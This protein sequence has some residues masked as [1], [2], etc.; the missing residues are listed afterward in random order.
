MPVQAFDWQFLTGYLQ[1]L[2]LGT[3]MPATFG[4]LAGGYDGQYYGYLW[5]EVFS[6][7]M[8]HSCFRKEG[9]MN[10]EVGMKYRNLILKPGGSLDGMDMLQNFLQ[11]EPNQKAFLMSRGLN[12][13]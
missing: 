7:D 1:C 4:H 10:P 5:S 9:I 12:A 2:L 11:R 13:S 6:M 8:F 3:N